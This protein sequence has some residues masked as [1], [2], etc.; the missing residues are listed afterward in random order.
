MRHRDYLLFWSGSLVSN[1][2]TFLQA[3]ALLWFI[4]VS[5]GSN[6]WVAVVNFA[7]YIPVFLFILPA[8]YLADT[9]DRRRVVLTCFVVML[10]TALALAVT[11]SLGAASMPVILIIV[12]VNGTAYTF[13]LPA[14]NTLLPLL[15]SRE[16]ML[17]ALALTSAQYN[18]GRVV[19]PALGALVVSAWSVA[20]A[21]Y[22]NSASFVF[23]ILAVALVR[24]RFSPE[25]PDLAGMA[26]H[27]RQGFRHVVERRWM[28]TV[29]LSFGAATFFGFS[30]TVLYPAFARD[31]LGRGAGAFGLILTMTGL[32]AV[33]GTPLV[34]LLNR[35]LAERSIIAGAIAG[36]SAF[37][38]AFSF[39]RTY[40]LTCLLSLGIGCCYLMLG[41][42]V[43]TV[44]QAR[45]E[46]GM[47]GRVTSYYSMMG[48]GMFPLGG[49][50]LGFIADRYSA[51]TAMQGG[52]SACVVLALVLFMV[53]ALA[54]GADSSLGID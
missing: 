11:K 52:A 13:C 34:T 48:L 7:Y 49:L 21:F 9:L 43:N 27:I 24:T 41:A 4:K 46:P 42:C 30:A 18:I 33:A 35:R 10:V 25:T 45:T 28:L 38:M 20:A 22:I 29:L 36:L 37:L 44:I 23:V 32:G 17:N 40:W 39:S 31:V 1:I 12:F 5:T 53:P 47:R 54:S 6:S 19:G 14:G 3:T 16:E 50:L 51:P 26:D 15:V 8:G 2:G